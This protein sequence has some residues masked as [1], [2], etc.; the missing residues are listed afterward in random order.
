MLQFSGQQFAIHASKILAF[1]CQHHLT[2][3]I[4]ASKLLWFICP[5]HVPETC[6]APS[7]KRHKLF[8]SSGGPLSVS[9]AQVGK[10]N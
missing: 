6:L 9:Q 8:C 3:V 4:A 10:K 1:L 2:L 5:I 7:I